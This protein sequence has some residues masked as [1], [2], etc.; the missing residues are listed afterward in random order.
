MALGTGGYAK[1][2]NAITLGKALATF[3]FETWSSLDKGKFLFM[4]FMYRKK[5]TF[6]NRAVTRDK[7]QVGHY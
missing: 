2:K 6:V 3:G 1:K 7:I 5:N 4:N